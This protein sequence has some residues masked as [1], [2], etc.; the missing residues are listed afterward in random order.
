MEFRYS[1]SVPAVIIGGMLAIGI[2]AQL[3]LYCRPGRATA[4]GAVSW[5]SIGFFV[6]LAGHGSLTILPAIVYALIGAPLGALICG[7]GAVAKADP[8]SI[9]K[10]SEQPGNSG[11]EHSAENNTK[12]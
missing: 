1:N 6:G 3:I 7:V 9:N 11:N 8:A 12:N 4:W 2:A 5:A 10:E